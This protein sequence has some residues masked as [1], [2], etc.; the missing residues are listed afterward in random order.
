MTD[1]GDRI[2]AALSVNRGD[3]IN[4]NTLYRLLGSCAAHV[5]SDAVKKLHRIPPY[6]AHDVVQ[7][8]STRYR[9]IKE[10]AGSMGRDTSR[11]AWAT[12]R[13]H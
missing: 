8:M 2:E 4:S 7:Y 5:R 1:L 3:C 11:L 6:L 9:V 10:N 12:G 13:R